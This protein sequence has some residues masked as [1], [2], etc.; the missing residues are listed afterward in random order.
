M[1]YILQIYIYISIY[2]YIYRYLDIYIYRYIYIYIY[3]YRY[4]YRYRYIYIYTYTYVVSDARAQECDDGHGLW[5][6]RLEVDLDGGV[7]AV[8][9]EQERNPAEPLDIVPDKAV[10]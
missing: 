7:E 2:I 3:R 4:R 10:S 5:E 9:L 1:L 6:V 8:H